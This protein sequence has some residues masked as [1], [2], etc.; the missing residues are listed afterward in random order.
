MGSTPVAIYEI[1]VAVTDE[2][3][4]GA[5]EVI[6]KSIISTSKVKTNPAI[7]ALKI[8]PIAPAAPQPIM[9]IIVFWSKRKA[10]AKLLPI[11]APVSTIGASAPTEPP[12][13][14]V[15]PEPAIELHILWPL[16]IDLR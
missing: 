13:P 2:I 3:N 16:I 1:T 10:L 9:S 12:K 8:P 5:T 11:A 15:S 7:G 4:K 14:I 6:V